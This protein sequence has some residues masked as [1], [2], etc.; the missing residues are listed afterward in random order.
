[1]RWLAYNGGAFWAGLFPMSEV[2]AEAMLASL[3]IT[4][5]NLM[6]FCTRGL[7]GL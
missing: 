7:G 2:A 6:R 5:Y 3:D 1:M 4:N